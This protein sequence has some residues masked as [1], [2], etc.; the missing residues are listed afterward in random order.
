M[1]EFLCTAEQC[2]TVTH[3]FLMYRDGHHLN[4][5]YVLALTGRLQERL[6]QAVPELFTR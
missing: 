5:R 3:D 4:P 1:S 6:A 2:L